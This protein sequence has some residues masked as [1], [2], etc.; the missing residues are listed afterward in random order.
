MLAQD[1]SK[2]DYTAHPKSDIW[3]LGVTLYKL[4]FNK[5][6][7]SGEIKK[8]ATDKIWEAK[9]KFPEE[10]KTSKHLWDLI[11]RMLN[12]VWDDRLGIFDCYYHPW[13]EG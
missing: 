1:E 8:E 11:R 4:C 10:P 13:F 12:L 7:F 5:V 9:V 2:R 3:A 6:P